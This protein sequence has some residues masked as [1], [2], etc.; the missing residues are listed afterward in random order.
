MSTKTF[1][2]LTPEQEAKIP[3]YIEKYLKIGL[4][5]NPC[6]RTAAENAITRTYQ[7]ENHP[8]PQ[9]IWVDSPFVGAKKAA[10]LVNSTATPTEEQI[11]DQ[12]SKASFG[13]FEA[14]WVAFYDF[15]ATE[16]PVERDPLIDICIDIVKN[17][18]VYWTLDKAVV[19]SEKPVA[20]HLDSENKLH[21]PN[22]L[23]LEY[24]NGDGIFA[25]NGVRYNSMLD[26]AITD[27]AQN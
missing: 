19:I 25:L 6:D 12:F 14:Y 11:R 26:M 27:M 18:G 8:V 1:D 5:T 21:N 16:L 15:V 23:A 4:D 20:I 22:G 13:S 9:F 17:C 24:K 3:E 2:K 10:E 7:A